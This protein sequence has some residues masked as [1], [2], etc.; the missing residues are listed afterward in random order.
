MALA[1]RFARLLPPGAVV[2]LEGPLGAGKTVFVRGMA[3]AFGVDRRTVHSPSFLLMHD[4]GGL[5][6]IDCYRLRRAEPETLMETGLWEALE[7]ERIKAVEWPPAAVKR[8]FRKAWKVRIRFADAGGRTIELPDTEEGGHRPR[9]LRGG[10]R[11]RR[12]P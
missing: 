4:Y 10:K 3:Q 6:H 1:R 12:A 2:F 11:S 8:R 5:V 7:G 9:P